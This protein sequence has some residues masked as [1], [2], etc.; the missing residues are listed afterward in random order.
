METTEMLK[1]ILAV[2]FINDWATL[3]EAVCRAKYPL[4]ETQRRE[5]FAE[6]GEIITGFVLGRVNSEA[7]QIDYDSMVGVL[8]NNIEIK[9]RTIEK[10]QR[11]ISKLKGEP[12][13]AKS[14]KARRR[15][16]TPNIPVVPPIPKCKKIARPGEAVIADGQFPE[17]RSNRKGSSSKFKGVS[18]KPKQSKNRPWTAQA[19]KDGKLQYAGTH[20][21]ELQAAAATQE[22]LG[23]KQLAQD[24]RHAN[25]FAG[26]IEEIKGP[27][28]EKIQCAGCSAE[29]D[30]HPDVCTKCNGTSFEV[31]KVRKVN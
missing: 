24:M 9:D 2:Q 6:C 15:S 17:A 4:D 28:T 19:F 11:K 5:R 10:L 31:I 18:F 23:N 12:T 21:T 22:L 29:Y 8:R 30:Q 25:K 7:A 16:G 27:R 13:A 26:R 20:E 1:I 14:K 3:P